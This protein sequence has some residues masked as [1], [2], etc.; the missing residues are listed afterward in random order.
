MT[1]FDT[2]NLAFGVLFGKDTNIKNTVK[3][4]TTSA[5]GME[6]SNTHDTA[7]K[8]GHPLFCATNGYDDAVSLKC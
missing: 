7:Y 5:E 3:H 8:F 4:V 1:I 6:L 2:I